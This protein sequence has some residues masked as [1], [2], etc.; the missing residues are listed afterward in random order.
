MVIKE[1]VI[2][3]GATLKRI[4]AK[5]RGSAGPI[6]KRTSHIRIV[7]TD[8][9]PIVRRSERVQAKKTVKKN[10]KKAPITQK[11]VEAVLSSAET[12]ATA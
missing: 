12:T 6:R 10:K 5:A 9:I 1:A 11:A 4:T 8:E 3:E 7:L 2:G